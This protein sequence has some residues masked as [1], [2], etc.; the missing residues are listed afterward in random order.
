MTIEQQLYDVQEWIKH[1]EMMITINL[2]DDWISV[3]KYKANLVEFKYREQYLK[4]VIG[5][6]GIH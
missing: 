5:N 6:I 3:E 2:A 4:E 1:I